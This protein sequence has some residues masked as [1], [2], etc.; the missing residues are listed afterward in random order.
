MPFVLKII[1]LGVGKG[2]MVKL[3]KDNDNINAE[4]I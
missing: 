4:K 3:N 1:N 2:Q